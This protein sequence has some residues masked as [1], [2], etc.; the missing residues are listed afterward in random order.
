MY[1]KADNQRQRYRL[2]EVSR[3]LYA[4]LV[5]TIAVFSSALQAAEEKPL[6]ADFSLKDA[7]GQVHSLADFKGKPLLLHFWAA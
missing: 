3:T 6:A 2:I 4:A 5:L 1:S 7:K